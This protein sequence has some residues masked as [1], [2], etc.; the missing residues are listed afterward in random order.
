MEIVFATLAIAVLKK[1]VE[2]EGA[3]TSTKEWVAANDKLTEVTAA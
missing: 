3:D 1:Y 2:E